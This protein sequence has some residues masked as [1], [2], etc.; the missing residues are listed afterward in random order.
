MSIIFFSLNN[1]LLKMPLGLTNPSLSLLMY[2]YTLH[3]QLNFTDLHYNFFKVALAGFSL[4]KSERILK[5]H[6]VSFHFPSIFYENNSVAEYFQIILKSSQKIWFD[7]FKNLQLY[8]EKV[9]KTF[10]CSKGNKPFQFVDVTFST[11]K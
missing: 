11:S 6:Y 5:Y 8:C 3:V 1:S 7:C 2:S 9:R 10:L 4:F